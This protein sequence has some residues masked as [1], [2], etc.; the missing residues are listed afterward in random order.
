LRDLDEA[1]LTGLLREAAH[2]RFQAKAALFAS[3]ARHAGWE[4]SLWEGLFRALG[5]KH[6]VWPMQ[7]LA[8]TR[9]RWSRDAESALVLQTR[10]LGISGL[11]SS[12]MSGART[13]RDAYLRRSW[14]RW[15]RERNEFE[16]CTMPKKAWRFHGLR[17]AN[18]PQRRLALASHWL[19][20]GDLS[21]RLQKWCVSEV[22]EKALLNSL[23]KLLHVKEDEFWSWHWTVRSARLSKP[24]PLLGEKRVTDLAINVILPWL[25]AR[26]AEGKSEKLQHEIER[27]YFGWPAAEDNSVLRLA[28]RRLLAD[29]SQRNFRTAAAQQG[30]MQIVRDFCDHSNAVCDECRFPEL[31]RELSRENRVGKQEKSR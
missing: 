31:V 29:A 28:R 14:D 16:D 8:E 3:R 11:L 1:Q 10:L 4:Q 12:E 9:P 19:A 17:P 26:A 27:R 24:Q 6:N 13:E 7:C 23:L 21:G 15:W 2:V 18:H 25:A 22:D 5:Y 30:L 20:A